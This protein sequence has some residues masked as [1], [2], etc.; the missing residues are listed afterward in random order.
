LLFLQA[1]QRVGIIGAQHLA[2]TPELKECQAVFLASFPRNATQYRWGLYYPLACLAL[3]AGIFLARLIT[4]VGTNDWLTILLI[5]LLP[6]ISISLSLT[7]FRRTLFHCQQIHLYANSFVSIDSDGRRQGAR[8]DQLFDF[9][10]GAHE[11]NQRFG[12]VRWDIIRAA[13]FPQRAGQSHTLKISHHQPDSIAKPALG[14][15][16]A[17]QASGGHVSR[18][19]S[20]QTRCWTLTRFFSIVIGLEK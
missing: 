1:G 6:F 19:S 3:L 13:I 10:R 8:W 5:F 18:N 12:R 4:H 15:S 9:R 20:P 17:T 16:E 14:L 11:E 7:A 2:H